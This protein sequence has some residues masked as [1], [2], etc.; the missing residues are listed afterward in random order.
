MINSIIAK[1]ILIRNES[2]LIFMPKF[3]VN[4]LIIA[5]SNHKKHTKKLF[6]AQFKE[7]KQQGQK[8]GNRICKNHR[9]AGCVYSVNQPQNNA[10]EE[11]QKHG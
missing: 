2:R 3:E 11:N 6:M 7:N 10:H 8:T 1:N 4:I 9:R 5:Q